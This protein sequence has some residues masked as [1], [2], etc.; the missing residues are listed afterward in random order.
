MIVLHTWEEKN[1]QP[2]TLKVFEKLP[3]PNWKNGAFV[4]FYKHNCI[5]ILFVDSFV[6]LIKPNVR[7]HYDYCNM[8]LIIFV[9]ISFLMILCVKCWQF[10]HRKCSNY[11]FHLILET[12]LL[13]IVEIRETFKLY[14]VN[15]WS[16]TISCIAH[17]SD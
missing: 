2:F 1:D 15:I 11:I 13:S 3:K 17:V 8:Y 16:K 14:H 12:I 4:M 9:C 10:H 7:T 5:Y 6:I